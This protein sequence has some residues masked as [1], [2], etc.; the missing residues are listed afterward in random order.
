M[1]QPENAPA[2]EGLVDVLLSL[3]TNAEMTEQ[4]GGEEWDA[5]IQRITTEGRINAI[6]EETWFYFLEVLPPR[7]HGGS[8]FAFAE[9][10]ESLRV[11]WRQRGSHYCRQL[12]WEETHRVCDASGLRRDYGYY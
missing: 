8:W 2:E 9:G 10:D 4:P 5:M 11:F 6:S 1:F 3:T 7:L 12:T